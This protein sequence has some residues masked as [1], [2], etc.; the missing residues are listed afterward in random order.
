MTRKTR[1]GHG[2]KDDTSRPGYCEVCRAEYG[3]LDVHVRTEAHRK[4]ASDNSNFIALDK[5][6][7]DG[8][9]IES[10]LKLHGSED[11]GGFE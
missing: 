8:A 3:R 9:D 4:F 7:D 5:L 11:K 2:R 6:I 10:F 1:V